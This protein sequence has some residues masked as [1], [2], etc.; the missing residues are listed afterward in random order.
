MS[1]RSVI[2]AIKPQSSGVDLTF[3]TVLTARSQ[4]RAVY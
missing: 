3:A 2:L 4:S 1:E